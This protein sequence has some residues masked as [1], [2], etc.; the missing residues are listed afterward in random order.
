M[1][2]STTKYIATVFCI[3]AFS[4]AASGQKLRFLI[5]DG[6]IVQHAGSIGYFSA[7][8][9][10]DLFKNRKGSLDIM[11][12]MQPHSKGGG[13]STLSTKFAIRPFEITA[14]PWLIIHPVNPGAF[15]SY[16]FDD[17]LSLVHD[18]DQYIKGY[19]PLSEALRIH[20]S[21][22]SEF[23][24]NTSTLLKSG[25]LKSATLYY[26]V[27]TNDIYLTNYVQNTKGLSVT[28]IFK[29]GIGIKASF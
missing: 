23:K 4:L 26:E 6:A 25:K 29:A 1:S 18:R 28:D 17:D 12:G 5:P 2:A 14:A 11:Y 13:F 15:L 8:I 7:G 27:N 9:D 21:F 24:F 3:I 22:S 16:T 19:Y 10:Y 20:L